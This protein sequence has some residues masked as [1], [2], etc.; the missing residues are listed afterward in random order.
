MKCLCC[1]KDIQELYPE[2]TDTLPEKNMWDDATVDLIYPS[3][4]SKHDLSVLRIALCDNCID[5]KLKDGT[6]DIVRT[7]TETI[8]LNKGRVAYE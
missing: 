3:Y 1:S 5:I 4:G 7:S 8:N 2:T 6:I